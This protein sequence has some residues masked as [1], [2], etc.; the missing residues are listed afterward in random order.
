MAT[1]SVILG[2]CVSDYNSIDDTIPGSTN[3][4]KA[5]H[6]QSNNAPV[7]FGRSFYRWSILDNGL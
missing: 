2:M 5:I 6:M 3:Y 7:Q 4:I 1:L